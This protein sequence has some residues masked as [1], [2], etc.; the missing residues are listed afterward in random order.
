[1]KKTI[2]HVS[3]YYY[4]YLGGIETL[5]RSLAEGMVNYHNVVVCSSSQI[6]AYKEKISVVQNGMVPSDF[7]LKE[8][9]EQKIANIKAKY[10]NKP[11]ALF[12]GRHLHYKGIYQELYPEAA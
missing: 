9:E 6:F 10:D 5:A 3:K 8:G 2:L 1:M 11:L 7:D 12:V 4:P